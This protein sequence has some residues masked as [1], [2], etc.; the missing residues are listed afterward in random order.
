MTNTA[1]AGLLQTDMEKVTPIVPK[2]TLAYLVND[3]E[4]E[5]L[6]RGLDLAFEIMTEE[7]V[8]AFICAWKQCGRMLPAPPCVCLEVPFQPQDQQAN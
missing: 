4:K 6:A 8:E 2:L 1:E 5:E 3:W 7:Q